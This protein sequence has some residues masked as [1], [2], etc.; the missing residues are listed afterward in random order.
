VIAFNRGS[1]PELIV[2]GKTGFL[3]NDIA[4]ATDS[5]KDIPEISRKDCRVFAENNFT[6]SK[7]AGEY[8]DVYEKI[9]NG[10]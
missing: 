10:K 2:N 3:V 7:M 1:M 9:I 5:I 4:E 8:I 6:R